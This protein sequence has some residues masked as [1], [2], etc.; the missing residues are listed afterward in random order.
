MFEL[1]P[2]I[3]GLPFKGAPLTTNSL[4]FRGP[5]PEPG[6]GGPDTVTIV[7]LGDSIM[8]GY[9]VPDGKDYLSLLGVML[10]HRYPAKKWRCINTAVP[11]YNTVQEVETLR[12]KGLAFEPD[13]VILGLVTNDLGMPPYMRFEEDVFDWSRSFLWERCVRGTRWA[14]QRNGIVLE[15]GLDPRLVAHGGFKH[16]SEIPARHRPVVGWDNVVQALDDLDAL[17][18]EHDFT[19]VSFTTTEDDLVVRMVGRARAHGWPHISLFP[20]IQAY[21]AERHGGSFSMEDPSVYM[22][23]KLAE[24]PAD[25]HPSMLQHLMAANKLLQELEANGVIARLRK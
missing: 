18:A 20:E 15:E 12:V 3:P 8:F 4:G 25:G 22:A 9:G 23:S 24:S 11:A 10:N 1:K 2:N 16:V 13:L 5:E 14:A 21:L 19:V 6:P 7:G 17:A